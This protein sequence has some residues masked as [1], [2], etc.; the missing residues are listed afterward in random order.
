MP[1]HVLSIDQGT[2]S[3]RAIVFDAS[4]S[5]VSVVQ[6]EHAQVL[7]RAGWVEHDPVEIWTNTEWAVSAALSSAHL[8]ARDIAA[9][10]VTNQRETAVGWDR[11][12]GRPVCNA[13]VWQDTRTQPRIDELTAEG[14]VDRFADAARLQRAGLVL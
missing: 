4:G 12:T 7:P 8:T 13:L 11:N 10:G 14:G 6:R 9:I 5:I 1:D 3:T 2:T